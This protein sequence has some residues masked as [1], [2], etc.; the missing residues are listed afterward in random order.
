MQSKKVFAFAF[1]PAVFVFAIIH[2]RNAP[3]NNYN[4]EYFGLERLQ[5]KSQTDLQVSGFHYSF[6]SQKEFYDTAFE[7]LGNFLG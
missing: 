1:L 3:Q 5:T 6:F 2:W 7:N 4:K